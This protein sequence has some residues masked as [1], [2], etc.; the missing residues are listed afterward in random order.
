ML[1]VTR[2]IRDDDIN[3]SG[4]DALCPVH[5]RCREG[6]DYVLPPLLDSYGTVILDPCTVAVFVSSI[7]FS[8][9]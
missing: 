7:Y 5:R 1:A 6:E 2:G 4:L 3:A 8:V 9:F